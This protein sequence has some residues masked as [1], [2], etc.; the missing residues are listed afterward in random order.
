MNVDKF[1]EYAVHLDNF[2][3]KQLLELLDFDEIEELP[4]S[5]NRRM[6]LEALGSFLMGNRDYPISLYKRLD[7]FD[8]R[9]YL[10]TWF[11]VIKHPHDLQ[12]MGRF[13][14]NYLIG[15]K[16]VTYQKLSPELYAFVKDCFNHVYYSDDGVEHTYRNPTPYIAND[17]A[18]AGAT[19]LCV[20][21]KV[22]SPK[23]IGCVVETWFEKS[24]E[25]SE[26][27]EAPEP[28][29]DKLRKWHPNIDI[30]NCE[31]VSLLHDSLQEQMRN[32]RRTEPKRGKI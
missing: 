21:L 24:P 32:S 16:S 3:Q 2:T 4:D 25:R 7:D 9:L 5:S 28:F 12:R 8:R 14:A 23:D 11:S 10:D 30:Y 29:L 15:I 1:F 13:V 22:L 20:Y 6:A 19:E 18:V 27:L 17:P 26:I 31:Q